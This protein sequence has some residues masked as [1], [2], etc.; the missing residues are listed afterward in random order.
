MPNFI[1]ERPITHL[2]SK[3]VQDINQKIALLINAVVRICITSIL[4]SCER[5]PEL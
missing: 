1:D 5:W 2:E 4:H 3:L